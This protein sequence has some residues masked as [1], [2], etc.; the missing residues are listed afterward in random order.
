MGD[1]E[2]TMYSQTLKSSRTRLRG[3]AGDGAG[4]I[5]DAANV[6]STNSVDLILRPRLRMISR[7]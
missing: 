3:P 4:A 6:L 1:R 7:M 2:G 5:M